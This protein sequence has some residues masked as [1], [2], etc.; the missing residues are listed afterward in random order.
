MK[1]P[2][3]NHTGNLLKRPFVRRK[4]LPDSYC[5]K[6]GS[7]IKIQYNWGKITLLILG[8]VAFLLLLHLI[9]QAMGYP[10]VSSMMAGGIT[11]VI[12]VIA[13]QHPPFINIEHI[14]YDN[15]KQNSKK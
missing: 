6:C 14:T 8:I 12:L 9:L 3:C 1:C 15:H 4:G 2:H 11:G 10:G 7:Q 5:V 13:M